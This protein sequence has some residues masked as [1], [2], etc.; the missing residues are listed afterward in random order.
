MIR[1]K[2]THK[3]FTLPVGI[4]TVQCHCKQSHV[5]EQTTVIRLVCSK[6]MMTTVMHRSYYNYLKQK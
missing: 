3:I 5:R 6:N 1:L 2:T 4:T